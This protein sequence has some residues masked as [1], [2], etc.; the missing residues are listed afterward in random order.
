MGQYSWECIKGSVYCRWFGVDRS[1]LMAP[2]RWDTADDRYR[3][4]N[5]L[6][7]QGTFWK[8]KQ[9]LCQ[10]PSL[11][12]AICPFRSPGW[13]PK[14]EIWDRA[15]PGAA[16]NNV[17][18]PQSTWDSSL[19]LLLL[20]SSLGRTQSLLETIVGSFRGHLGQPTLLQYPFGFTNYKINICF[21]KHFKINKGK[22]TS[23]VPWRKIWSP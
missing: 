15:V 1:L 16:G 13:V 22:L 3:W 23:N 21:N 12:R 7:P 5:D 19:C 4:I 8:V 10:S 18:P 11:L 9:G 17:L 20:V 14:H 6:T 2:Y